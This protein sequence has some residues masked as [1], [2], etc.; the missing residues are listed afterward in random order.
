MIRDANRQVP[1]LAR[2]AFPASNCYSKNHRRLLSFPY[3]NIECLSLLANAVLAHRLGFTELLNQASTC[4]AFD[5]G[6]PTSVLVK[7][8][9]LNDCTYTVNVYDTGDCT[10]NIVGSIIGRN[11]CLNI[12]Q[13]TAGKAVQVDPTYS[14]HKTPKKVSSLIINK[15]R[16][17][18]RRKWLRR[19]SF[20]L[21][22][23]LSRTQVAPRMKTTSMK[24]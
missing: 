18:G 6:V 23:A 17:Q 15:P 1:A 21:V 3:W 9:K 8:D 7:I 5:E 16:Q 4:T 19:P 22:S 13:N 2:P 11:G 24:H 10:G 14:G 12:S 20:M